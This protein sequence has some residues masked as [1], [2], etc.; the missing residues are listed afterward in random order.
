MEHEK[1][2]MQSLNPRE[3]KCAGTPLY[4]ESRAVKNIFSLQ[5][6][7]LMSFTNEMLPETA[8][9]FVQLKYSLFKDS[10]LDVKTK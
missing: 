1:E 5:E 2:G 3:M 6:G 7:L 9:V 10:F 8:K 4:A